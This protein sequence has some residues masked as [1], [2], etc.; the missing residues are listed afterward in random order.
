MTWRNISTLIA[1]AS[2]G[3]WMLVFNTSY[4]TGFLVFLFPLLSSYLCWAFMHATLFLLIWR[5]L[6]ISFYFFP[7]G[8]AMMLF[9]L[10]DRA[11]FIPVKDMQCMLSLKYVLSFMLSFFNYLLV[12]MRCECG[13]RKLM[14]SFNW[15]PCSIRRSARI[16]SFWLCLEMI[17][18]GLLLMPTM[19][20]YVF[21]TNFTW[22]SQSKDVSFC[23]RWS[24]Q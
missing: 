3:Q 22:R 12:L 8:Y 11:N 2:L 23:G 19:E 24:F 9:S 7:D 10:S 5:V 21:K 13:W 4:I 14:S 15:F 20:R 16:A 1:S 6:Y 18:T 17:L